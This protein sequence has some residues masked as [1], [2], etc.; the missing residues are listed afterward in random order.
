MEH[1]SDLVSREWTTAGASAKNTDN[2]WYREHKYRITRGRGG[3]GRKGPRSLVEI[4]SEVFA[5]HIGDAAEYYFEKLPPRI[6][7]LIWAHLTTGER[8]VKHTS[9]RL[10]PPSHAA[11]SPSL[12]LLS[13]LSLHAFKLL[14]KRLISE[15][16]DKTLGMYRYRQRIPAPTA[17]LSVYLDPLKSKSFD[18][19]SHL[20]ID[21][22]CLF[23]DTDLMLL[24]T[25]KN[26]GVLEIVEPDR[27]NC[28][29][30]QV[31]DR[32][33]KAWS[34]KEG[35]F[36]LL[37]VLRLWG[38]DS[39]T[40]QSVQYASAFPSLAVFDVVGTDSGWSH[41]VELGK[42]HGWDCTGRSYKQLE[43][44][45]ATDVMDLFFKGDLRPSHPKPEAINEYRLEELYEDDKCTIKDAPKADSS[46]STLQDLY[47]S[48]YKLSNPKRRR[49]LFGDNTTVYA[50]PDK[51]DPGYWGF[52]AYAFLG[53]R[54]HNQD[55]RAQGLEGVSPVTAEEVQLPIKPFVSLSLGNETRY[56]SRPPTYSTRGSM[57]TSRCIFWRRPE[58]NGSHTSV[59]GAKTKPRKRKTPGTPKIKLRSH[60]RQQLTDVLAAYQ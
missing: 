52:W 28:H 11:S 49:R 40:E 42:D 27:A 45:G 55:V 39:L 48:W 51:W 58:Q 36:P 60:K 53:Q 4:C 41:A 14:S 56:H 22:S 25:V 26:L 35:V 54:A 18:F 13:K 20:R 30:P 6:L 3:H 15:D 5:D 8:Y 57:K 50:E 34:L 12:I 32:L 38:Y 33:I 2:D 23:K 16:G 1:R 44:S 47:D 17:E 19:I 9:I 24:S 37:R 43:I 46:S 10:G 21:G 31:S 7:T 29:F 59:K